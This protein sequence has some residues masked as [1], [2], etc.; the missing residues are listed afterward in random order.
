MRNVYRPRESR[1][2][3]VLNNRKIQ[4]NNHSNVSKHERMKY[5]TTSRNRRSLITYYTSYGLWDSQTPPRETPTE[6]HPNEEN[7]GKEEESQTGSTTNNGWGSLPTNVE[8]KDESS[9]NIIN[10]SIYKQ[11]IFRK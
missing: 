3:A 2:E 8:R 7:E 6:E 4:T 9:S 10:S 1:Y 5:T 11:Y